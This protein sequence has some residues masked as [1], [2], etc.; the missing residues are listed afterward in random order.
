MHVVRWSVRPM[1]DI[2]MKET[3]IGAY[4]IVDWAK[5]E[6]LIKKSAISDASRSCKIL[7]VTEFQQ[8]K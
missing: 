2:Q 8:T 4:S 1:F 5:F 7:T 3:G 6:R